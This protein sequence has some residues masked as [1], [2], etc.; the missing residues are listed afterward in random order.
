M[1]R[2][3]DR[4]IFKLAYDPQIYKLESTEI[5]KSVDELFDEL[6]ADKIYGKY[7]AS[8]TADDFLNSIYVAHGDGESVISFCIHKNHDV[9]SLFNTMS[10]N[11]FFEELMNRTFDSLVLVWEGQF[12]TYSVDKFITTNLKDIMK[13]MCDSSSFKETSA[14]AGSLN[15]LSS[16]V[17][18]LVSS[19]EYNRGKTSVSNITNNIAL[20]RCDTLDPIFKVGSKIINGRDITSIFMQLA[21]EV[22]ELAEE[23][24]IKTDPKYYKQPGKDGILGEGCDVIIAVVD[25]LHIAGYAKPEIHNTIIDKLNKWESKAGIVEESP[26]SVKYVVRDSK[27]SNYVKIETLDK[28]YTVYATKILNDMVSV[29]TINDKSEYLHSTCIHVSNL[30]EILENIMGINE[31]DAETL[32]RQVLTSFSIN[33]KSLTEIK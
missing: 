23:V 9:E 2:L 32:T 22:G 24:R 21:S 18:Q 30:A 25:L 19:V 29:V 17:N 12:S 1:S 26:F 20:H 31:K 33:N 15:E 14:E 4:I 11:L 16:L 13:S 10:K 27:G 28:D 3:I 5:D 8:L 7:V 6:K